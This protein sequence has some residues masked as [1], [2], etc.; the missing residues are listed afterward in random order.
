MIDNRLACKQPDGFMTHEN[1]KFAA[2]A[3]ACGRS[4]RRYGANAEDASRGDEEDRYHFSSHMMCL[5]APQPFRTTEKERTG[6]R[7]FYL[8]IAPLATKAFTRHV[9]N[10]ASCSCDSRLRPE[11]MQ[12]LPAATSLPSDAL[13]WRLFEETQHLPHSFWHRQRSIAMRGSPSHRI[14]LFTDQ[15]ATAE[16]SFHAKPEV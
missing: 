11:S 8:G 7:C 2:R 5:P 14:F 10:K 12:V 15:G 13:G 4:K 16:S 9:T 6:D 1:G 3:R